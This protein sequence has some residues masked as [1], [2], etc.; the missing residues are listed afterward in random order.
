[1]FVVFIIFPVLTVQQAC[2]CYDCSKGNDSWS[3]EGPV[4]QEWIHHFDCSGGRYR[5]FMDLAIDSSGNIH[6]AAYVNCGTNKPR[7]ATI[8]YDQQGNELWVANDYGQPTYRVNAMAI[9]IDKLDNT[10]ITGS[11]IRNYSPRFKNTTTKYDSNGQ[12]VWDVTY[13]GNPKS[14]DI[15]LD[16]MGNVF[17]TGDWATIKYDNQGREKWK[18]LAGV[19]IDTDEMGNAFVTGENGTIKYGLDGDELWTKSIKGKA[20]NVG[21]SGNVVVLQVKNDE[22]LGR[23]IKYDNDGNVMWD[24]K[25]DGG[26]LAVDAKENCYVAG[27][28]NIIKYDTNGNRLWIAQG[29]GSRITVDN[30]ENVYVTGG[31]FTTTK[32]DHSGKYVWTATYTGGRSSDRANAI[33]VDELFNVYVIGSTHVKSCSNYF[34]KDYKEWFDSVI[35]KYSQ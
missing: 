11:T 29:G 19:S 22:Q 15:S 24:R 8:V 12:K 33:L 21:D 9:A 30:L 35:I 34:T 13:D 1:M 27:G 26:A 31:G 3:L 10:Y 5:E 16:T 2:T 6:V 18:G 14:I 28:G 20:I 32:Y 7:G 25:T 4:V 23:L 17:V